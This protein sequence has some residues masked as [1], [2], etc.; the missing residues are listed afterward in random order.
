MTSKRPNPLESPDKLTPAPDTLYVEGA[1]LR[2][3]EFFESFPPV[4]DAEDQ[5]R[6]NV[7][8]DALA[9]T[10][11]EQRRERMEAQEVFAKVTTSPEEFR[12]KHLA[13]ICWSNPEASDDTLVRRALVTPSKALLV[14]ACL[15]YG[16]AR[17]ES[18]W[19]D[20][21]SDLEDPEVQD[22]RSKTSEILAAIR[23]AWG[24]VGLSYE[25]VEE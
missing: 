24:R 6:R 8:W 4:K 10:I 7:V 1:P 13:A 15:A 12:R 11:D 21:A 5:A 2:R 25:P 20:L 17:V 22:A 16:L 3:A 23:V 9:A 18:T 19:Q 14:D